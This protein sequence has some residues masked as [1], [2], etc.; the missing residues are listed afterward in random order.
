MSAQS[1]LEDA[2]RSFDDTR[3]CRCCLLVRHDVTS[4]ALDSEGAVF[5]AWFNGQRRMS[6]LMRDSLSNRVTP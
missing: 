2:L 1:T 6:A 3:D 5:S 4:S